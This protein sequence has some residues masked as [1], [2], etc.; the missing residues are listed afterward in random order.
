MGQLFQASVEPF[1]GSVLWGMHLAN[2]DG[3]QCLILAN[4]ETEAPGSEYTQQVSSK[5][6]SRPL[7]RASHS[8]SLFFSCSPHPR[9]R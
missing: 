6:G 8:D 7:G 4:R 3:T 1:T 5:A 9:L 2:A